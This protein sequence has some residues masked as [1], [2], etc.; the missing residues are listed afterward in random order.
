MTPRCDSNPA[1]P[2]V[3]VSTVDV[4]KSR[5]LPKSMLCK[6]ALMPIRSAW[7]MFCA[8][9]AA[10][11]NAFDGMQPRLRQVPPNVLSRSMSATVLPSCAARNAVEYPPGPAPMMTMSK[12]CSVMP[13]LVDSCVT[14]GYMVME[15]PSVFADGLKATAILAEWITRASVHAS[16]SAASADASDASG[17]HGSTR[18]NRNACPW[19]RTARRTFQ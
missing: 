10:V 11:S 19:P 18:R 14:T 9:C 16:D 7:R 12:C 8:L 2:F 13:A 6:V 15:K 17:W 4:R 1:N 3:I 5:N